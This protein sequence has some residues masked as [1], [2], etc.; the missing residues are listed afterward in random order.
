MEKLKQ[1]IR[2]MIEEEREYKELAS[3]LRSYYQLAINTL[4]G[5]DQVLPA[6]V[7]IKDDTSLTL[8]KQLNSKA[9]IKT[10][11]Q[12]E[13]EGI[14]PYR[15]KPFLIMLANDIRVFNSYKHTKGANAVTLYYQN[16]SENLA[17]P[18]GVVMQTQNIV[19]K[20]GIVDK[21]DE[22]I[23]GDFLHELIHAYV[24]KYDNYD[25]KKVISN[26]DHKKGLFITHL[27]TLQ[28]AVRKDGIRIPKG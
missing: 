2:E 10:I 11:R 6:S 15:D 24:A 21:T 19:D 12:I 18:A 13:E 8:T 14:N 28:R 17:Y 22:E 16:E 7:L 27:P 9:G 5:A 1:I 4:P 3:K 25:M 23:I 26:Y 20:V